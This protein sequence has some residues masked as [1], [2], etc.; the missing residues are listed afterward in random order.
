MGKGQ[1][2][3]N[4]KYCEICWNEKFQFWS[5]QLQDQTFQED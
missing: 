2:E 3:A 4:W 1:E 5:A